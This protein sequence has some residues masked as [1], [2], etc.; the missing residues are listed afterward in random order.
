MNKWELTAHY[1][2]NSKS[3]INLKKKYK[4][5]LNLFKFDLKNIYSLEKY[6]N[7]HKKK[8]LK[9]DAFVNLSGYFKSTKFQNFKVKDLFD[10]FN[11]NSFSSLL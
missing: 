6:L 11:V 8:F 7:R 10:H 5:R 9:Y 2:T 1:N 3:L 4:S